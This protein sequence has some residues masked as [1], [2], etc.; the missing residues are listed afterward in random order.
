MTDIDQRDDDSVERNVRRGTRAV[1]GAQVMS[2]LLSL[3]VLGVLYRKLGPEPFG[4]LGMVMPALL[5][6]RMA[7]AFGLQVS[8]V[9]TPALDASTRNQVFWMNQCLGLGAALAMLATGPL[10]AWLFEVESLTGLCGALALTLPLY[11]LGNVHQGWWERKLA[12]GPLAAVRVGA[13]AAGGAAALGLAWSGVGVWALVGQQ[14]CELAALALMLWVFSDWRPSWQGIAWDRKLFRFGGWYTAGSFFFYLGQNV[15][16]YILAWLLGATPAGRAAIGMYSQAFNLAMKPVFL[17]TSPLS[18][19]LLP[20]LARLRNDS[21]RYGRLVARV[22]SLVSLALLPAAVGVGLV[23]SD[24]MSILGGGRWSSAAPILAALTPLIATQ[25]LI[26]LCGSV[27]AARGHARQLCFGALIQACVLSGA[28]LTILVT[29]RQHG[30]TPQQVVPAMAWA[31]SVTTAVV[32]LIP[33]LAYCFYISQVAL[34]H[35]LQPLLPLAFASIVMGVV[36]FA[37]RAAIGPTT[38]AP[39]RLMLS[40]AVGGGVYGILVRRH[41]VWGWNQWRGKKI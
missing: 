18:S 37:L 14:A 9:Q 32:I 27:L 5:L 11:T 31:I 2:Q 40:A 8:I 15:D 20:G 41:L 26:N 7:A 36:V 10:L 39:L 17:V 3:L 6:A 34:R 35:V 28:A 23:A 25:G 33:Y 21:Q 4:L 16:K 12:I 22:F 24:V 30:W 1:I 19:I 29:A 13:Q 38:A